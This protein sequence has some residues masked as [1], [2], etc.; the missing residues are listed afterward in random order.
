[1]PES[2]TVRL[3]PASLDL[4]GAEIE[5]VSMVGVST[6]WQSP[7]RLLEDHPT[8]VVLIDCPPSLGLLTLNALVAAEELLIPIQCEYYALGGPRTVDPHG[9]HGA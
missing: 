4:A 7:G 6:A 9:R 5:L 2:D 3:V 1:M 8:D